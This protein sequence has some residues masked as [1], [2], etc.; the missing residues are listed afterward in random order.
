VSENSRIDSQASSY[1]NASPEVL[2]DQLNEC[3]TQL[4]TFKRAVADRDR[5]I[6]QLTKSLA[7]R[8]LIVA[9][10][11]KRLKYARVRIALLYAIVGAAV[12]K[13][14]ELIVMHWIT[15]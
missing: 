6:D 10:L 14:L 13:T 15:K 4:R 11:R 5:S 9:R 8:D 12:A 3:W 7:A 1:K 2:R